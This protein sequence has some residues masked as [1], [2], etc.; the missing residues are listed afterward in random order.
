VANVGRE[1]ISSG[2]YKMRYELMP[3]ISNNQ[4]LADS[5]KNEFLYSLIAEKLW[6]MEASEKGYDTSAVIKYSMSSLEKLYV[7]DALYKEEIEKKVKITPEEIIKGVFRCKTRLALNIISSGDSAEI[8]KVYSA[9]N[10]GASF[11]SLLQLR[12]DDYQMQKTPVI[13]KFGEI[14]EEFIE[15]TL[16][17]LKPGGFSSPLKTAKG[18]FIFKLKKRESV[19]FDNKKNSEISKEAKEVVRHRKA[20]KLESAYLK[21]LL[22]SAKVEAVNRLFWRIV[23]ISTPVLAAKKALPENSKGKVYLDENDVSEMLR[24]FG[25]DSLNMTF[26]KINNNNVTLRDFLYSFVTD[27]FAIEDPVYNNVASDIKTYLD[28]YIKN[29][30]LSEQAYKN[31]LQ[32][33][34]DVKRE[35]KW[36]KEN[37][38]A[39]ILRNQFLDSAKVSDEEVTEYYKKINSGSR[40]VTEVN[41]IEILTNRLEDI[42][43]IMN[44]LQKGKD[45]RELAKI[46]NRRQT[47]K[48]KDGQSGFFPVTMYGEIGK[49]AE[50]M[51]IG[52]VYGPLKQTDGYSIFKLIDKKEK[53]DSLNK[54]F[55]DLKAQLKDDL[56]NQKLD[57][58]FN[59]Y[60]AKLAAKYGVKINK[61]VLNSINVGKVNM[62]TSRIMGFGGRIAAIPYTAPFYQWT[63]EW[64]R[65]SKLNL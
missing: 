14:G 45:F 55:D 56:F 49:I 33:M 35:M 29:E 27:G 63:K 42:E 62:F 31:G 39:H 65:Q 34:P 6:A 57:N 61:E 3:H 13:V 5:L 1:K 11:D 7:R 59:R 52:E 16:Y 44:A 51:K 38:T 4:D 2:E 30:V 28:T 18:W 46:Y 20:L 21:K 26:I 9:L 23:D 64:I 40:Q 36:W 15:D 60:T 12:P 43:E 50:R 32:N 17:N 19:I 8:F 37:Y 25:S 47:T 58:S 10:K 53:S 22:P 54:S 24:Q 48:D 41:I